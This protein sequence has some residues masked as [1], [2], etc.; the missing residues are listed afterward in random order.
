MVRFKNIASMIVSRNPR[1]WLFGPNGERFRRK[2]V[3]L[4]FSSGVIEFKFGMFGRSKGQ[5]SCCCSVM[6]E[7]GITGSV[8]IGSVTADS[9]MADSKLFIAP[10]I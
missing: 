10:G 1:N 2:W 6:T 9:A 5:L 7:S 4:R 3:F 8:M